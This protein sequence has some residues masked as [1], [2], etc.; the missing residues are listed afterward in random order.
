ME[1]VRNRPYTQQIQEE[2]RTQLDGYLDQ[3]TAAAAPILARVAQ[4]QGMF[5]PQ[6]LQDLA[7]G[8]FSPIEQDPTMPLRFKTAGAAALQG[9][10]P[11]ATEEAAAEG[12]LLVDSPPLR[13]GTGTA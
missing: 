9:L 12:K 13:S 11:Y 4:Q 8:V 10:V 3:A 2:L 5:T 1:A 6:D 7:A